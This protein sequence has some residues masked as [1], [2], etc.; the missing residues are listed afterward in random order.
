MRELFGLALIGCLVIF[1]VAVVI[2]SEEKQ[3]I[4]TLTLAATPQVEQRVEE[5]LYEND[6]KQVVTVVLYEEFNKWLLAN[7]DKKIVSICSVGRGTYGMTS[8]FMI[9]YTR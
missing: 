3:K 9:V 4:D 1:V 8:G 7:K 5:I 6:A 2:K